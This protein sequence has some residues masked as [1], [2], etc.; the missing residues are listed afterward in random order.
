MTGPLE[1]RTALVTAGSR[2]LGADI[3]R[4]LAA[5][6]ADVVVNYHASA[7]AAAELVEELDRLHRGR[8]LAL[9]GDLSVP[10]GMA[11]LAD[12]ALEAVGR[13][14]VLVNNAGPFSMTPFLDMDID[15]WNRVWNA[16]VTA[17]QQ[18]VRRLVPAMR[19]AGW[20]RVVNISAGSAYLRN[21]TIYGLAKD[22]VRHLTE[23]LA[24]E[25]GPEVT[26]NAVAPGQIHESAPDVSAIDPTFVD[27]AV[28]RT[29]VG[30]LVR[31]SEVADV[32]VQLCGPT[33]DVLTGATLP[34][35]GGWRL[36]R[37]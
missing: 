15:E 1:G 5:A 32:I 37:F 22:A 6:G 19:D 14:D 12:A 24:L 7:G 2:T 13:V 26:V 16:N 21:H 23:S 4:A 28:A 36:N 8:H 34:L 30:R 11:A 20:G 33:F 35:D 18:L 17:V 9:S 3:C 27:R 29:P 10:D 31:R 25:L